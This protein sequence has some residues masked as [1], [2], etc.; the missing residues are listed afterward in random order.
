MEMGVV[1][2]MKVMTIVIYVYNG[3]VSVCDVFAYF[4]V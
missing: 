4:C 1:T 2:I 3:E